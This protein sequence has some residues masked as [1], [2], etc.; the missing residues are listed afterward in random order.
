MGWKFLLQL[1]MMMEKCLLTRKY[2][3]TSL[4]GLSGLIEGQNETVA[5]FLVRDDPFA[6]KQYTLR[7]RGGRTGVTV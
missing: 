6:S 7:Q 3:S 4:T 1:D 2:D 5:A